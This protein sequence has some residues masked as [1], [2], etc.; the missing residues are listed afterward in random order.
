MLPL[1][2]ALRVAFRH[3]LPVSI[4]PPHAALQRPLRREFSSFRESI[5]SG[6]VSLA[7]TVAN[8]IIASVFN[9]IRRNEAM[10]LRMQ[11]FSKHFPDWEGPVAFVEGCGGALQALMDMTNN[12]CTLLPWPSNP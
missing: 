6:M 12:R 7:G 8:P 3:R 2:S 9:A 4:T 5:H 11:K 10:E 1:R